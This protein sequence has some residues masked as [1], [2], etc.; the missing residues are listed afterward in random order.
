M[1]LYIYMWILSYLQYAIK[2]YIYIYIYVY[3]YA[4]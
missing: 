2:K 1:Y 4:P 3:A